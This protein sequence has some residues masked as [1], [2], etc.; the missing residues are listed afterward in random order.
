[1]KRIQIGVIG[2]NIDSL[3]L[4]TSDIA[5][6]VGKEIARHNAVLICGGLGGVMEYACKGAKDN[7]GLTIGIVPQENDLEAN[8]FCDIVICSGVGLSR[9]FMVSYSSNAIISVGGGVGTLI[10]L[11]VGYMAK[12][13]MVTIEH[14]GGT[15]DLYGGKFLDE[16]KRIMIERYTSPKDAVEYVINKI[17]ENRM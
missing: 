13:I 4:K 16:R 11:C 9:D 3:S 10:E 14:S 7:G 2:Y 8:K 1:M 17:K 5:Y 6:E 15:S 12:K